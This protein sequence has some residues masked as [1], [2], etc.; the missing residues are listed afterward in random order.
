MTIQGQWHPGIGDPTALGWTTTAGYLLSAF[1]CGIAG[2]RRNTRADLASERPFWMMLSVAMLLLGINK[3]LDL[4]TW[5]WL[6]ARS[7]MRDM[8]WYEQRIWLQLSLTIFVAFS[9]VAVIAMRWGLSRKL[10]RQSKVALAGMTFLCAFVLSRTM[11]IRR[12]DRFLASGV[13]KTN[14]NHVV[15]F[16]GVCIVLTPSVSTYV[17]RLRRKRA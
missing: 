16:L 17:Q 6:A 9:G 5:L 7:A 15:E 14:L 8:G 10:H 12:V 11:S 2:R 3:Q 1:S 13:G 4:Q